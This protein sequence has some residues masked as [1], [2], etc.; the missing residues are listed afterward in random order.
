MTGREAR[1]G[2]ERRLIEMYDWLFAPP[3]SKPSRWVP[4]EA[5]KRLTEAIV[6][7]RSTVLVGDEDAA[8]TGFCTA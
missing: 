1:P 5:R 8:L 3:G 2:E 7:P 4:D 6:S